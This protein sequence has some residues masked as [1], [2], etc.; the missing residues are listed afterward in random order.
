MKR[1]PILVI[2]GFLSILSFNFFIGKAQQPPTLAPTPCDLYLCQ[3]TPAPVLTVA[4]EAV[5]S[6]LTNNP[7]GM[8]GGQ[9]VFPDKNGPSDSTNRKIVLVRA[10]VDGKSTKENPITVY[11]KAFDVDDPSSDSIIDTN[12]TLGG[13]NRLNAGPGTFTT[14]TAINQP[15]TSSEISVT[16]PPLLDQA[17]VYLTVTMQP[18]NNVVVAATTT[19]DLSKVTVAETGL[20]Y[21]LQTLLPTNDI[22]RTEML[23][24]WRRLHIEVDSMGVAT[25]NFVTGIIPN[26]TVIRRNQTATITLN[27]GITLQPNRFEG[28]RLVVEGTSLSIPCNI[29]NGDTCNTTNTVTVK[30]TG[31]STV[32]I[33]ANSSFTLYDDDDFN[34]NDGAVLDG[35]DGENLPMPDKSKVTEN[36]DDPN[37]NV[38]APAYVHP[39]YDIGNNNDNVNFISNYTSDDPTYIRNLYDFNQILTEHDSEFWTVYLLGAYQFTIFLDGD[40]YS[41]N[42]AYGY[43]DALNYSGEGASIFLEANRPKEYPLGWAS[44]PVSQAL[45]VAHELG[46]LFNGRH[47]DGGLMAEP[48]N[49]TNGNFDRTTIV[50]IRDAINP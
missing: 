40:P 31:T 25:N 33:A 1:L 42:T 15:G 12:G 46:H 7:A 29:T 27:T 19:G 34:D 48:F 50:R 26:D 36:S 22:K 32:F 47:I 39:K 43:A 49:I 23:T 35:D 20:I 37:T 11:F 18:G 9:R 38:F 13:D 44:R 2:L 21:N 41:E 3:G 8:G 24:T 30:N 16:I 10:T 6:P 17:V 45:T 5:D 4:F 14:S 28:G